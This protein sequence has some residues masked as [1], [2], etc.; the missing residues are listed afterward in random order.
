MT[1][2][3][4]RIRTLTKALEAAYEVLGGHHYVLG[5]DWQHAVPPKRGPCIGCT[6]LRRIKRNILEA[7][8]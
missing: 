2:D 6:V 4:A 5:C 8:R 3:I 1:S 7:R